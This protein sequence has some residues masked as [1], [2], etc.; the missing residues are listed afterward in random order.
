MHFGLYFKRVPSCDLYILFLQGSKHITS[1]QLDNS[2]LGV[3]NINGNDLIL[4]KLYLYTENI[5]MQY[6]QTILEIMAQSK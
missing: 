2:D 1:Y 4:L 3:I 6:W 5:Y